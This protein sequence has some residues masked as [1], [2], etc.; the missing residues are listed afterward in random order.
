VSWFN[1]FSNLVRH[2]KLSRELDN[3]LQFHID[4]RTQ[5]NLAAGMTPREARQDALKRFGNRTVAKERTHEMNLVMA[6]ETTAQDARY[7]LRSLTKS[8]GFTAVALLTLA[9]GIGANTAVFTVVNGVLLRPLPFPDEARLSL[10]SYRPLH[11]PFDSGRGL[12][13]QHYL[14]FQRRNQSFESIATFGED[15]V[16]LTGAGDAIRVP[17]AM[18]TSSFFGTLKVAPAIGRAFSQ[19]EE[20]IENGGVAVLGD[21][22]WRSRFGADPNVLGKMITLNGLRRRVIGVMP[23][24]FAFPNDVELW[25]PLAVGADAGNSYFRP[26]IGRLRP[27]ISAKQA[28][29]ELE[30]L[31]QSLPIGP[32]EQRSNMIPEILPLKDLLVREIRKSLLIFMGS[33]AFVLLIACA[34]VANLSLMRAT[35]RRQEIAVRT[36]L[37]ARRGRVIRQL[38][39]ES[40]L[41]SVGGAAL[42]VAL[43]A[44]G[45]P[46]LLALA[47]VG[48]IPRLDEVHL[49]V[50]VLAFSLGVGVITGVLFGLVP[51]IQATGPELRAALGQGG[52]S[53][54]GRS[55]AFRSALVI[56]EIALAVVLL[57]GAGLM[58]KSFLRMRAVDPGFHPEN[59]LT[60]TVDL[61]EASYKT[62][63]IMRDFHTRTIKGLS[64]LPGVLAAGAVNWL[65]LG[66]AL[67]QGDFH[68]D[69]GRR[70][71]QGYLVDKPAV[72]PD[73]FRVMGIRLLKGRGFTEQDHHDAPGVAVVSQS[74]AQTLWLRGDPIGKRISLEDDAKPE[75]WL[76]IIGVVDD[77]RQERLTDRPDPAI[78]RPYQ[79]VN[80]PFFLGHMTFV[81]RTAAN[82]K[83]VAAAMRGILQEEDRNQPVESMA[84]MND[85][86]ASKT[87]EPQ[88]QARLISIFSVLAL[89][90]SALGIHGVLAYAVAQRTREIGIRMALGAEKSDITHMV[91]KRSL[92]LV[93]MGVALGVA[94]ALAITRVLSN[95]LFG[96]RPTDP[97]TFFTVTLVLA[98]VAILAGVVPAW[99]ATRVDPF[100]ALRSE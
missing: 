86:I 22:L 40:T 29:V 67:I 85:L 84:A 11:G 33:V 2:E 18:V 41:V 82:P 1:R 87:A 12:G 69:G 65:P 56:S 39:T 50:W 8:P 51:A 66:P 38:L 93:T 9:L 28:K 80:H 59:I 53:L 74:V 14:E 21:S 7:A 36:A 30:T 58:L 25:L 68:L 89:I 90:L 24:R 37:G 81:V 6:L 94:G 63:S 17:T 34:N 3:E 35:S 43:A 26:V 88:F 83:G 92:L 45:V 47:P 42:G 72:S 64:N 48:K 79:Q 15:S 20:W 78:Y 49:D 77:V 99:R 27:S 54:T 98:A 97:A 70:L 19:E 31:A 96:V 95:F 100:V 23:A 60:M 57:T 13:D 61:P 46:A 75:D 16:A 32:G 62:A 5:D 73:Y 4:A 10:V 91:L 44:I 55:E 52:R 76:T 71:P